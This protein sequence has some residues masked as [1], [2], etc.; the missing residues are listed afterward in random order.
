MVRPVGLIP[1]VPAQSHHQGCDCDLRHELSESAA[2]RSA[3]GL[4]TREPE[5]CE[6][7][8]ACNAGRDKSERYRGSRSG[9]LP[10]V[11]ARSVHVVLLRRASARTPRNSGFLRGWPH[12]VSAMVWRGFW[13][14]VAEPF[15][16]RHVPPN[17]RVKHDRLPCFCLRE[18]PRQY[19]IQV[20][21]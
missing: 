14:S 7:V 16:S 15:L 4:A 13:Y 8:L 9:R 3:S 5:T 1:G 11:C 2:S 6:F 20:W 17:P 12:R 21:S 10:K 19:R 18:S